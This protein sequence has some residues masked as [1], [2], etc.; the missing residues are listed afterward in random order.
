VTAATG[1][2]A[3]NGIPLAVAATRTLPHDVGTFTG[4]D[5]ELRQLREFAS[6]G[7]TSGTSRICVVH[8]MAGVGK[9]AFAV[10][11]AHEVADHFPDGQLFVRLYGH[12]DEGRPVEPVDVLS[13]L[14]L[15]VDILP[16]AIPD[17]LEE[18]AALWRSELAKRRMLLLFDDA[19]GSEQILSLLPG[20]G[21]TLVLVTSRQRVTA[22]PEADDIPLETMT[23]D[24]AAGL[25]VRIAR[26][27]SQ[28]ADSAA[29]AK[30]VSLC[31]FLP[32]AITLAA[33]HL[34]QH[35]AWAVTDLVAAITQDGG[36]GRIT[37]DRVAAM[38]DLSY[39]NLAPG[40]QRFF[41]CLGLH[42][43]SDID[44]YAA[45]A[46]AGLDPGTAQTMLDELFDYHLIEEPAARGRYR[47]HDLI[48][49][50]A[51]AAADAADSDD[52]RLAA[53]QRLLAYY[54]HMARAADRHLAR[55]TPS[56][57]RDIVAEPPGHARALA[58]P[59]EALAWMDAE[60]LNLHAAADYAAVSGL[61]EYAIA[62]PAAMDSYLFRRGYWRQALDLCQL[63]RGAARDL[64]DDAADARILT[65]MGRLQYMMADMGTA[66]A[67]LTEAVTLHGTFAD[68][69]GEAHALLLLGGVD[70]TA[71]DYDAAV[72]N[73]RA[74]LVLYRRV[75]DPRGEADVAGHLGVVQ[76]ETGDYPAAIASQQAALAAYAAL[77][78]PIG[79]GHAHAY[80]GELHGLQGRYDAGIEA[81]NQ[82]LELFYEAD[83]QWN[84]AGC[85]YY[86]GAVQRA[87]GD[88]E[89]AAANLGRA[90][91]M[92]REAHD[93][94]DEAGVRTSI[95]M[96]QTATGRY[97]E[98]A[99]SLARAGEIYGSH[100]SENGE[101]E[102]LNSRGELALA[103][104]DPAAALIHH[105]AAL[106]TAVRLRIAR[107]EARACEGIGRCLLATG[108]RDLA[109]D[110]LRSALEIYLRLGSPQAERVR[111]LLDGGE[112]DG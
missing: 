91:E 70:Y 90:L 10:H 63:S 89:G 60:Y 17:G 68:P 50:Y 67:S 41:R 37:A 31:G 49:E 9:T 66:R 110:P 45:A 65:D 35:R 92:Y 105:R 39:R 71:G 99:A 82:A 22:L 44:S 54:L 21:G 11:F 51:R 57:A 34:R 19:S 16:G 85:L 53:Q 4:R 73:W 38:L 100:G 32:L 15:A 46:L 58:T 87:A 86:L 78:D 55:R 8:G 97:P 52:E 111:A 76:A 23:A 106:E 24:D 56:V 29:V 1:G 81:I 72:E 47:F 84:V 40:L 26:R 83:D 20:S 88:M 102:V 3:D 101:V 93:E 107:E 14:L 42:P 43:G 69:L 36:L 103:T 98:A 18:R 109:I 64:G 30:A 62:V 77:G 96:V 33:G 48:H 79:Q 6:A 13:A 27:P 12:E 75:G 59:A 74:A 94:W 7:V 108:E 95:G 112:A 25:F 80:L 28:Q 2:D 104:D 5:E 61:P